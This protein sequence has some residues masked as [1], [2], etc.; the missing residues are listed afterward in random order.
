M[1]TPS[2]VPC[3]APC[4]ALNHRLRKPT[5]RLRPAG[6]ALASLGITLALI[7]VA[8]ADFNPVALT[9]GS[10]TFDIV[11][12]SNTVPAL[13]YVITSTAGNGTGLGDNTC[14]EQGLVARAGQTGGN[15]G[16]P[17]HNTTFTNI[18]DATVQFLMPPDYSTNN[19]LMIDSTFSS[20]TFTFNTA[21]TA[22]NLAILGTGGGGS[23]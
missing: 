2:S 8:R 15:S 1:R 21:T 9:P 14:Y 7:S 11:V 12:E 6:S 22:T 17:I 23:V 18:N 16:I 19:D 10:Y 13:P 20:G 5:R 4:K 3:K